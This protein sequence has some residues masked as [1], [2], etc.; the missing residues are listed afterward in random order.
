[1]G[2]GEIDGRELEGRMY[3]FSLNRHSS[4]FNTTYPYFEVVQMHKSRVFLSS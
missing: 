4:T 2:G 1:M 3:F